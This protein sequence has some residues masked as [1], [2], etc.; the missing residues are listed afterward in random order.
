MEQ[1]EKVFNFLLS[2]P[3]LPG[4]ILKEISGTIKEGSYFISNKGK[5]VSF[6]GNKYKILK[7]DLSTGYERV[8]INGKN[9]LIHRL[10]ADAFISIPKGKTEVHHKDENPRNNTAEN[11]E[12]LTQTEHREKHKHGKEV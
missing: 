9:I 4:E 8:K 3:A 10:V 11:L 2:Y 12:W 6:C 1:L 5:V 7:P